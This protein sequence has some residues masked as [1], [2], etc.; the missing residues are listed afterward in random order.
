MA[1]AGQGRSATTAYL[2][3]NKPFGTGAGISGHSKLIVTSTDLSRQDTSLTTSDGS[4]RQP[5]G[6]GAATRN[7]ARYYVSLKSSFGG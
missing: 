1:R 2:K 5:P 7:A 6:A 4:G 3:H